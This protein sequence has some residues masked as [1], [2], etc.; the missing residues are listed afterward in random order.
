MGC[1]IEVYLHN[2]IAKR[3]A[4]HINIVNTG[5]AFQIIRNS[6]DIPPFSLGDNQLYML[7]GISCFIQRRFP[8][9]FGYALRCRGQRLICPATCTI[10]R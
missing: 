2:G 5:D 9:R 3:R 4:P 1:A 6:R 8:Y 7:A 10:V